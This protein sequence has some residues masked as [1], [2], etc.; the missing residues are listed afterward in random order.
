LNERTRA[1]VLVHIFG[2]DASFPD[3]HDIDVPIIDDLCQAFGLRPA[4]GKRDAAFFSFNATKCLTTG[5]GGAFCLSP[6]LRQRL[7]WIQGDRMS[8]LQARLGLSQLGQYPDYLGRR[9][10]IAN[11]YLNHLPSSLVKNTLLLRDRSLWFR[12]P[13]RLR[14]DF[15]KIQSFMEKENIAIR[16]GVD[17]L[18]RSDDGSDVVGEVSQEVFDSTVSL[19][20]YPAMNDVHVNRVVRALREGLEI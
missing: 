3:L 17:T 7:Q 2:I 20:I 11:Q 10:E 14:V 1:I 15:T 4:H 13:V 5:E 12:F 9:A 16:R 8:D 18:L 6:D 19:P